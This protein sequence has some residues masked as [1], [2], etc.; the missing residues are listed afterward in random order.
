MIKEYYSIIKLSKKVWIPVLI[1]YVVVLISFLIGFEPASSGA[2]LV[3]TCIYADLTL[4]RLIW[5]KAAMYFGDDSLHEQKEEEGTSF[6]GTKGQSVSGVDRELNLLKQIAVKKSHSR[7]KSMWGIST[8]LDRFDAIVA[9]VVGGS[10]ILGTI[11]WGY[12]DL[13]LPAV[14]E[15]A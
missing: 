10:A 13:F 4:N 14:C 15:C 1:G 8:S 2:V 5:R 12:A 6:V 11:I 9:R 7:D 3:G